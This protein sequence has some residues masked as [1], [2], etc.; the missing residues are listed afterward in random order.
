MPKVPLPLAISKPSDIRHRPAKAT[1][2]LKGSSLA[3]VRPGP[4][5]NLVTN[6]TAEAQLRIT[7]FVK[8]LPKEE[9]AAEGQGM[10]TV[11]AFSVGTMNNATPP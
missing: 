5:Q 2:L 4:T 6:P 10:W 1:A 8:V 7:K 11:T 3:S 9:M